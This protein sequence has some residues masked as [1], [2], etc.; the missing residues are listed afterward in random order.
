[1]LEDHETVERRTI[2]QTR[3]RV[4]TTINIAHI[5]TTIALVLSI[6]SWGSDLKSTVQRHDSEIQ[7]LS[8]DVREDRTVLREELREINRKMDRIVERIGGA[9]N[10]LL[11]KP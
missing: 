9:N 5:L 3:F 1:M 6:F 10:G 11:G 2:D 7:A 4:D 8:R